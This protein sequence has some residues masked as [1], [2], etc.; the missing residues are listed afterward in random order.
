MCV[1]E[2]RGLSRNR[3]GRNMSCFS[4]G[5]ILTEC[6]AW[7]GRRSEIRAECIGEIAKIGL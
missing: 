7:L 6:N 1:F 3:L 4:C 2:G 5:K